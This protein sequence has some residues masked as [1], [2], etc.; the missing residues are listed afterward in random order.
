MTILFLIA[1]AAWVVAMGKGVVIIPT[2]LAY[3]QE[4]L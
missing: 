4:A 2:D 3:A 1:G